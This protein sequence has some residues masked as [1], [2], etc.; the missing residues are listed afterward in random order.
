MEDVAIS[1]R[2]GGGLKSGTSMVVLGK[3]KVVIFAFYFENRAERI[4]DGLEECERRIRG[5]SVCLAWED[6]VTIYREGK[7]SGRV[8]FWRQGQSGV[9]ESLSRRRE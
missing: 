8:K 5:D 2:N 1:L 4:A 7:D 3:E 9:P 6:G